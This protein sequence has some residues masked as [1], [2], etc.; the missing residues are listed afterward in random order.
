SVVAVTPAILVAVFS[1]L[2]LNFGIQAWFNERV[3][4]AVEESRAVAHAYL[5]EHQQSVRADAL[6]MAN[7]LNRD[8]PILM[9][10][11]A[12]FNQILSAQAGLRS[13]PE[14]MVMDG[15]GRTLA[16][17]RFSMSLE[18]E[19]VLG[20]DLRQAAT[21][22]V[23]VLTGGQEDRVR[24]L[25]K[26]NR[27]ADAYLLVGRFIESRVLEHIERTDQ[28]FSQY[29]SLEKRRKGIQITFVM[30]F[31]VVALLLLLAAVWIG[32]TL[33]TQ[34]ARPIS[35][36]ITV[37][38]RVGKGDLTARVEATAA[39]DEIGILSRA[40]NRMTSQIDTQQKGLVE[41]NR[42]LGE[43]SRF[44]E[45]VLAGVSAGV[46]GL[47]DRGR[48]HLPNRSAS[49]LLAT[50]LADAIGTDLVTVV[51]EMAQLLDAVK[52][53]PD[54]PHQAEINVVRQDRPLSLI[55]SMAAESLDDQVIGYVV[56][57]DDITELLSAQR[58]AAWADVARRI[59]HEIRN[60]LTPIR[61]S[62][63][64][65]KRK[66]L[67]QIGDDPKTFSDCIETIVRQ[68]ED[69]GRMV[70]EFSS[71]ARMPQA[72]LKTE[73]L[74]E[75]CRQAAFFERARHPSTNYD[76]DLGD[77]DI[78]ISCDRR[79]INQALTNM[80]KNAVES[81]EARAAHRDPGLSGIILLR[82]SREAAEVG[83]RVVIALEDNG[84]GL[85]EEHRERL[86]EPY[87]TTR[88]KGTGL[89]LAIV[90]KIMEDH[91]GEVTL[92]NRTE[93]GAV[94]SL[95]FHPERQSDNS[96]TEDAGPPDPMQVATRVLI[97]G[98]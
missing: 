8:A 60:P 27:F 51:P 75:I 89:G 32:L 31:V 78:H 43:R 62:A 18:L 48:V 71:F 84:L 55:V 69:I 23:V 59:A 17:S 45:T 7:D 24:A 20:Q 70:D 16:R 9:R 82:L 15:D 28:A 44:T 53:R 4:T 5:Y 56:T 92:E 81:I 96:Q 3:R 85:P 54:R 57:F 41:A 77:E 2:F 30:I 63:E 67:K 93:G 94:I 34:L 37:A 1:A 88:D 80:F 13:L 46:I 40:F 36:L 97:D 26:L 33:A 11:R 12:R 29:K 91:H 95:V 66:Y 49:E 52:K 47:D 83:G 10:N 79:Q 64:R 6:A 42:Q 50:D 86:T 61:L 38:E 25:V 72:T 39:S 98:S 19:R 21:G 35:N 65:L 22:E 74:S 14:A 90:R 58:T 73:N 87:V 68:V 76:L